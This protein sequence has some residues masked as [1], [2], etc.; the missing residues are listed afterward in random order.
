[1]DFF[2]RDVCQISA[3]SWDAE[4]RQC[5]KCES[6]SGR[7]CLEQGANPK[8]NSVAAEDNEWNAVTV[9]LFLTL[10]VSAVAIVGFQRYKA[11]RKKYGGFQIAPTVELASVEDKAVR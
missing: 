11:I 1:M 10:L 4:T 9:P 7:Y 6:Q 2:A 5:N 3:R 8:K